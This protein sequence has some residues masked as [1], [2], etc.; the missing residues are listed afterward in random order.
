MLEMREGVVMRT[1]DE[2]VAAVRNRSARLRRSRSDRLLGA[3][4][5]L[6]LL[7]LIGL[8]GSLATGSLPA[9]TGSS[10]GLFGT[11][12][13]F[14]SSAGGYVLVAVLA[15]TIAVTATVLL[16]MRRGSHDKAEGNRERPM[17][18]NS[19][20]KRGGTPDGE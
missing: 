2:R 12:S 13:L 18:S 16:M 20:E 15:G 1:V 10:A 4:A 7:P 8:T 6:M 14:G 11:A 3:F 17:Q 19:K 9:P 5:C